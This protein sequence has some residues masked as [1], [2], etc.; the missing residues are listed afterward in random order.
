MKVV[1]GYIQIEF[2]QKKPGTLKL[3]LPV[4]AQRDGGIIKIGVGVGL[5]KQKNTKIGN[6]L[7]KKWTCSV[8]K[9]QLWLE[10]CPTL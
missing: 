5:W 4:K 6:F 7:E 10:T 1:I 8:L 2:C 9:L 3:E